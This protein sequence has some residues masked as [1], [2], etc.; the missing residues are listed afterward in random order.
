MWQ[1]IP[2]N[3]VGTTMRTDEH[4]KPA[5]ADPDPMPAISYTFEGASRAT[6][7]SRTKLYSLVRSGHLTI[8]KFGRISIL[9]GEQLR[10]VVRSH[11]V[12]RSP[13]PSPNPRARKNAPPPPAARRRKASE[14]RAGA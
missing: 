14:T 6:G 11:R 8:S 12:E 1:R 9:D 10:D 3:F 5:G 7:L 4:P 13:T 2:N